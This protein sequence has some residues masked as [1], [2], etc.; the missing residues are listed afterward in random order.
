M[1]PPQLPTHSNSSLQMVG[2]I[3]QPLSYPLDV[4]RRRMQL[5][6][7]NPETHRFGKSFFETLAITYREHGVL[8]GLYRGM[9]INYLR[10]VPMTAASFTA[11]E[12]TKQF[13]GLDTSVR[14]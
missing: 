6:M 3:V 11:Y 7:L 9:S 8:R 14:I 4:A 1:T 13:L 12:I 5:S 10:A 2:A